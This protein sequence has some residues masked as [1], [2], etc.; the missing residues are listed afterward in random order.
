MLASSI[1]ES[2]VSSDKSVE[3]IQERLRSAEA[4]SKLLWLVDADV[5]G[6]LYTFTESKRGCR[7]IQMI[8]ICT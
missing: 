6:F 3:V 4:P 2:K 1:V 5:C 8:G 7:V